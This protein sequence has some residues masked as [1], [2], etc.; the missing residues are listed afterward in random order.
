[1]PLLEGDPAGLRAVV[2]DVAVGLLALLL[3]AGELGGAHEQDGL[4]GGAAHDVDEVVDGGLGVLDEVEHGQEEL[5]V[6]GQDLGELPGIERWRGCRRVNDVVAFGHRWWL[7][8]KG[9]KT[10]DDTASSSAGAATDLS[11]F[12][13]GRDIISVSRSP[14]STRAR[15]RNAMLSLSQTTH[16]GSIALLSTA[17]HLYLLAGQLDDAEDRLRDAATSSMMSDEERGS[18]LYNLACVLRGAGVKKIAAR[19]WTRRC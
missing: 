17:G 11:T 7:L 13:Y 4:D 18:V 1:M 10:P 16:H 19:C 3:G 8:C 5:A 14:Y 15:P 9:R 2:D 6:L 12:H